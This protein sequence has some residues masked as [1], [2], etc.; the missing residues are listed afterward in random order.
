MSTKKSVYVGL[1]LILLLVIGIFHFYPVK[2]VKI[3]KPEDQLC[4]GVILNINRNTEN[5]YRVVLGQ[6]DSFNKKSIGVDTNSCTET[7]LHKLYI[8]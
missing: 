8:F 4:L 2:V 1:L 3:T 6:L 7:E 5:K